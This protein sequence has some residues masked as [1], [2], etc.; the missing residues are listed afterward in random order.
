[1]PL[2]TP[3][4]FKVFAH[5]SAWGLFIFFAWTTFNDPGQMGLYTSKDHIEGGG[6]IENLTVLILLPGIIAGIV[7]LLKFRHLMQPALSSA[8]LLL[9][10][11]AC[12]YFAGEEISWGQWLFEWETPQTISELNDQNETNFHNMSSWLDQKPRT[13]VELWIVIAG[14]IF[15]IYRF[16]R[17]T[18]DSASRL[19]W[20]N[21]VSSL[22][23]AAI[24]FLLVRLAS[25]SEH[26]LLDELLGSSELR[27][28]SIALFLSLF[29]IS[30][31]ARLAPLNK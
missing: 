19:Y 21:P 10:V 18:A 5:L 11:L 2:N 31:L 25:W 13:L 4:W 17:K 14:L 12:I 30:Y 24:C 23:S 22:A 15:P 8:W 7:A 20:F 6:L 29:L 16:F 3:N 1:M 27:E 9:W 28:L 26:D